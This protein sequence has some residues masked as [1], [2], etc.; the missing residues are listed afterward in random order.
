M[1]EIDVCPWC[2]NRVVNMHWKCLKDAVPTAD[3]QTRH[4]IARNR[5]GAESKHP[6]TEWY[7]D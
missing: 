1:M 3:F 5:W 2:H 4:G 7:G 6:D